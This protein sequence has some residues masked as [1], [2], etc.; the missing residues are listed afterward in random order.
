MKQD[1][2]IINPL[3][4]DVED[5]VQVS[6]NLEFIDTT[7]ESGESEDESEFSDGEFAYFLNNGN[8]LGGTECPVRKN[9][10]RFSTLNDDETKLADKQM[11]YLR[12]LSVAQVIPECQLDSS[13]EDSESEFSGAEKLV[14]SQE[15]RNTETESM[16]R[17]KRKTLIAVIEDEGK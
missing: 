2:T 4:D 5:P 8:F 14:S 9:K 12:N 17:K 1:V 3:S 16:V 11:Q 7:S 6:N 15:Y 10:R 13:S